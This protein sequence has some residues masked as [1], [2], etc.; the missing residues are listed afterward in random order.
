MAA[1]DFGMDLDAVGVPI[2]GRAAFAL[3]APENVIP[4]AE[5]GARPIVFPAAAKSL[6]LYKVDGGP[7]PARESEDAIE[8]FQAG[9]AISGSGTRTVQI[10]LAEH[11]AAVL[12]LTEGKVPDENGVIEV[13]SEL[14]NNRFILY[15]LTRYRNGME[16]FQQGVANVTAIEPDQQER[17]TV[18]GNAVTFTWREDELFNGKPFWQWGPAVPGAPVVVQPTGV[19]AGTPGHFTPIG[20]TPPA[21]IAELRALGAL[22]QTDAWTT[23]QYV[24]YGAGMKAHWGGSDW[25][26][27]EAA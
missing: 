8:F 19:V 20:A 11:N 14:P 13:D 17:G 5:M 1:D 24:E 3:V 18:E 7:T 12:E 4:K 10:T 23:G 21:S 6:G 2:T 9:Y 22:G 27:G 26:T 25:A 15:V 16:K